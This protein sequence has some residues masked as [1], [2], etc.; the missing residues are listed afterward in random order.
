[1]GEGL[2]IDKVRSIAQIYIQLEGLQRSITKEIKMFNKEDH[3]IQEKLGFQFL[4][5]GNLLKRLHG[6]QLREEGHNKCDG[7][8]RHKEGGKG[9]HHH[10]R[11]GSRSQM[12][13]LRLLSERDGISQREIVDELDIQPSSASELVCKLEDAGIVRRETNEDDKRAV[14]VFITDEGKDRIKQVKEHHSENA[15]EMFAGLTSAEQE[16]LSVLLGKL[17]ASLKEQ[18]SEKGIEVSR[19][20]HGRLKKPQK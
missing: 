18:G 11:H 13:L 6:A 4:K 5:A 9:R 3:T 15:S 12:H 2:I 14:K 20:K 7:E 17:I 1:M 16:Q 10:R 19:H 8:C